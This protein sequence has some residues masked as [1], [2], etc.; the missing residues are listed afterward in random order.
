MEGTDQPVREPNFKERLHIERDNLNDKSAKLDGFM[1]S[2]K[3]ADIH[4]IQ[5]SLLRVQ[6][7]AMKTY[8]QCLAERID[9]L[10][11]VTEKKEPA[12]GVPAAE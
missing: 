2:E 1:S 5:Q 9:W 10:E 12:D 11:Q 3:F 7:A 6:L 8:S 4:P